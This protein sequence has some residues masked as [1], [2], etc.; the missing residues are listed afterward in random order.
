MYKDREFIKRFSI[1]SVFIILVMG[2]YSSYKRNGVLL[3]FD[4]KNDMSVNKKETALTKEQIQTQQR[5][6]QY[7]LYLSALGQELFALESSA[8]VD[9]VKDLELDKTHLKSLESK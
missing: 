9:L 6:N 4:K 8:S 5:I 1:M 7:V 2:L 3:P